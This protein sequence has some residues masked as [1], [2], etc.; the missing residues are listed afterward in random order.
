[1]KAIVYNKKNKS[2]KLSLAELDKPLPADNE[3]LVK[4]V[5]ASLNAADYRSIKMGMIPKRKIYGSAISGRVEAVG[6]N[7]RSFK[8]GD[9]VF[10]D[11]SDSGFGGLAEFVSCPEDALVTK[12]ESI[13]FDEAATLGVASTTALCAL[14]DEGAIQ[15]GQDVLIVGSA[16]GVG[17]FAVQLAHYYGAKITAVCSSRNVEQT[18]ALGAQKVI[19]YT[20]DDFTKTNQ[21]FDLILAINGNYPLMTYHKL[22]KAGGVYVMVG[23]A[24]SQILKSLIMGKILSLGSKKMK[25]QSGKTNPKDLAFLVQLMEEGKLKG[26]IEKQYSLEDAPKAMEYL[27]QGHAQSKVVINISKDSI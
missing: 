8:V 16:G 17:I 23:G 11:L 27:S 25:T 26:L 1:M 24:L 10:G 6:K 20:K 15:Q 13:S 7:I 14:R 9:A 3:V 5:S 18:K 2:N 22:L 19:D 21:S 4:V 12:P